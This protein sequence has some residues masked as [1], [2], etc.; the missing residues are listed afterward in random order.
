MSDYKILEVKNG[1]MK[2][3]VASLGGIIMNLF[4]PDAKGKSADIVLGHDTPEEYLK[5][6]CFFGALVGRVGN[7]ISKGEF[8]LDGK[9]YKIAKNEASLGNHLHGGNVGFDKVN[10]DICECSGLGWKGVRLHYLSRD[11]EEGYA[12]NLDVSVFYKLTD[13]NSLLIEYNAFTDRPTLCNLTQHSY[14][15]LSAFK[16]ADVLDHEIKINADFYTANNSKF[17]P[18][19]EILSV[20][21]TPL[22]LR[23]FTPIRKGVE[24]NA[25]M[26]AQANGGY[27]HNFVLKNAS[28][29][30][31]EAASVRDNITGRNMTVYTTEVGM[32][33]YSANFVDNVK[34]KGGR[35]Y[36]KHS[37]LCLETQH[38]PDA[39][40]NPHFPSI[41]LYPED[42]YS[43]MTAYSFSK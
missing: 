31:V 36:N 3:R 7:R 5:S 14:F 19:G 20:K 28:G 24:S 37:G 42:V 40:H 26:I 15:N 38:F 10:W 22:D 30:F 8:S 11:G 16:S 2:M 23:K 6:K 34:G 32:Q 43:S 25:P 12:G 39:I 13:D 1:D 35:I 33:F 27:D 9:K 21:N 29:D 41:A 18:T 17:I 4:A